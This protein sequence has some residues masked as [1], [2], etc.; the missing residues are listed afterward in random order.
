MPEMTMSPPTGDFIM[1]STSTNVKRHDPVPPSRH[2]SQALVTPPRFDPGTRTRPGPETDMMREGAFQPGSRAPP[3][4]WSPC[5]WNVLLGLGGIA[6]RM[7]LFVG[8]MKQ[9]LVDCG[10]VLPSGGLG[11]VICGGARPLRWNWN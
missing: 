8:W 7:M 5:F 11:L 2:G 4:F 1:Q 10:F 3:C 9:V 6:R